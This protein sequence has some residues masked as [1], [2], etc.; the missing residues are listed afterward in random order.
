MVHFA[1]RSGGAAQHVR[2]SG[3]TIQ[4]KAFHAGAIGPYRDAF[5]DRE[6]DLSRDAKRGGMA[7]I[8][9]GSTTLVGSGADVAVL[10]THRLDCVLSGTEILERASSGV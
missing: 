6:R 4:S 5:S 2:P 9:P 8:A 7:A 3:R 1:F 10:H